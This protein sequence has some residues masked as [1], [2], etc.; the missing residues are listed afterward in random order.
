MNPFHSNQ[1]W[2]ST[3]KKED[4]TH[5]T[6]HLTTSPFTKHRHTLKSQK[7]DPAIFKVY[8]ISASKPQKALLH[9]NQIS[10]H[11]K[12]RYRTKF[13]LTSEFF[14]MSCGEMIY[15]WSC[16]IGD[17]NIVYQAEILVIMSNEALEWN[18]SF[19]NPITSPGFIVI[20]YPVYKPFLPTPLSTLKNQPP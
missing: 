10:K 17:F 16:K 3:S 15:Y 14:A 12:H 6:R 7:M 5:I 11:K 13:D 1:A 4:C 18:G 19:R 8:V 2:N 20:A 9:T